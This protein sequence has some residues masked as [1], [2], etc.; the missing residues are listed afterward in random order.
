[1]MAENQCLDVDKE[2]YLG[3]RHIADL[4][5]LQPVENDNPCLTFQGQE[6]SHS[7]CVYITQCPEVNDTLT[8]FF[9]TDLSHCRPQ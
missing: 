2:S 1:M 7:T 4:A 9:R 8:Q 5:D 3:V 6:L